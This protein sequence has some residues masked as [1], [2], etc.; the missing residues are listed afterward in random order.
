MASVPSQSE[1]SGKLAKFFNQILQGQRTVKTSRESKQFFEAI[2]DQNDPSKCCERLFASVQALESL[3]AALRSDTS[4]TFI[5][6]SISGFIHYISDPAVKQLCSGQ[7][8]Q[9]LLQVLL[10]PPTLWI[11]LVQ[12]YTNRTMT[13]RTMQGFSWILLEILLSPGHFDID[14][15]D[16][17]KRVV[18]VELVQ[19]S[20]TELRTVLYK[21]QHV[22]SLQSVATTVKLE[23]GPGGRHDNDFEDFRRIAIYPTADEF[24][25]TETPFYRSADMVQET[26]ED[27]RA[28]V[29]IDNQFRLLREDML[30]ELRDDHQRA[31]KS[32]GARRSAFFIP[33]LAGAHLIY[34]DPKQQ[35]QAAI[36]FYCTTGLEQFKGLDQ[37][38]R[39]SFLTENRNFLKHQSF[40]CLIQGSDIISFATVER[41]I[42]SLLKDPPMIVLQ[43]CGDKAFEKTLSALKSGGSLSFLSVDTPFFAYEPVL[44]CLQTKPT[45]ALADELINYNAEAPVH[46]SRLI[47][48]IFVQKVGESVGRDLKPLLQT[49]KSIKLDES[50]TESLK[51]GL[52]LP[53][54]LIQGPP[55][56]GK[57]FIGALLAKSFYDL[58]K[59]IILVVC[60][61]NHAL[62]QFLE[63]FLDIGV[64][65]H[66]I[67][68]LGS[69]STPKTA[70][71]NLF[72]QKSTYKHGRADWAAIDQLRAEANELRV[73]L[74]NKF[75]DYLR[76]RFDHKTLM[77][78]LEFSEH[79]DVFMDALTTPVSADGMVKVGRKGK[80]V[81]PDYLFNQWSNGHGPGVF[82][83]SISPTHRDVWTMTPEA[84]AA[85]ISSW[86]ASLVQERIDVI[87]SLY[88]RYNTVQAKASEI[89]NQRNVE[90]LKTKRII[91]CTTT[92]AAKYAE[93]I[94]HASPGI[95]LVEE[96]G[97][98]LESHILTALS[99]K[100]KQLVLIGDH[101]Q[102]RPKINNYAL[103]VEKGDGFDL[104][105]SLFE[106]LILAGYPHTTLMKQH[107]MSPE[108][109]SLIR[110]L[111]YP[112]LKDAP[113]TMNRPPVRGLQ[114]RVVFFNH[115][116]P[117][118]NMANLNDRRDEGAKVSKR[119]HF[120]GNMVLKCVRYLAQQ[121]YGT[122]KLV[123]LTPY[124]GQLHLLRDLLS[125]ENDPVLNDLDSHDLIKAGLL[126]QSS[127]Y[128]TKRPIKIS[129]IDNYQGEES[130]IVLVSLTRCNES[131]DIG[132]MKA[133]ER[134]NVLLSRARN[135]MILLGSADTF[136]KAHKGRTP[137]VS[138][139]QFMR[140]H[141]H[142]Y[143]GL[144]VLCMQHPDRKSIIQSTEDFDQ[145]CPDGGCFEPCGTKL[146]CGLHDCPSKCHQLADHSKMNCEFIVE[147][148]CPK[149]H[150]IRVR[151]HIKD[152]TCRKCEHEERQK[153]RKKQRDLKLDMERDAKQAA[154]MQ[155]LAE[156]QDEIDFERRKLQNKSE[157]EQRQQALHQRQRDLADIKAI[158]KDIGEIKLSDGCQFPQ[159]PDLRDPVENSGNSSQPD[160]QTAD[161]SSVVQPSSSTASKEWLYQKE[162]EGASNEALDDLM[163][164][165]GLEDVK[166]KF[167]SIKS[168]VDTALR[169]NINLK[170]ERFGAAL[171]GN[172]GTGKTTVARLYARFLTSVGALPGNFFVE[173]SGSK[174]ANEGVSGCKK[175]LEDILNNG[176]GALF[177]DEAYQLA[178]GTN[179]GG[180]SVLDF[181][182][183]EVENTTGKVVFILAG[184]NK[185]MEAFFAHNPGIPSR[186]PHELQFKDYEDDELLRILAHSI[187]KKYS[188]RMKIEDGMG[189]LYSRIV[190][191]RI[192]RGHG[193]EGF[194]NAR[195][196]E[197]ARAQIA[198][199]QA[200]RLQEQRRAKMQVDDMLLTKEDLLGPE[201]A[202]A[203]KNCRAWNQLQQ[204]IG[205]K[206]VK[207]SVQALFDSIQ[208]NYCRELEE[209]PLVEYSLNRVFL[210][211]PGTGKTSVAKLY[212]QILADIGLLSKGEVV[213]KNP[214]DFVGSVLGESEKNTKGI[215]AST[216]GKVLVIDEAYGLFS[217]QG[218]GR[219][220][221]DPYKTAVIDTI[222]A[223]VQ[224]TPGDDRC[225][226]LLGYKDQM[227]EMFQ[228]VNPGLTRRF[229]LDAAFVFEDFSDEELRK[230]F[231]LKI[232]G[233]GFDATDQGKKVAMEMLKRAHN[234]PHFGNAGEVDI[235]LNAAKSRHQ[236]RLSTGKTKK[237]ATLEA[238]DFDEDFDRGQRAETN[239]K[240]LFEGVVGCEDI[241][242]QLERYQ[243]TGKNLKLLDID[244]REQIPFNFLFRGPP[245]TGKTT[246][247]KKMGKIYYD[248]G[249]LATAEV[250]ECSATE[251][252]GQYVGSTG[253]KTQK[254][255]EKALG[256][257][258]F[259]DEAY[260]LA[261]GQFAKEAMDEIVDCLTKPKFAQ[262]LVMILA[263]YD[264]Q[265]NHLMTINPGLTSRFPEAVVFRPLQPDECITLLVGLLRKRKTHLE[266]SG[267]CLDMSVL[268]KPTGSFRNDLHAHFQA[269]TALQDW[270]NAR[271][272]Q[273]IYKS[274]FN[275]LVNSATRVKGVPTLALTSSTVL[276]E[277]S[278]ILS[279]RS[280]RGN[281]ASSFP[282]PNNFS[283]Q[284]QTATRTLD[285]QPLP[286]SSHATSFTLQNQRNDPPPPQETPQQN[287][288][289]EP[290][291]PRDHSVSDAKWAQLQQDKAAASAREHDFADLLAKERDVLSF[292][293]KID[294][295]EAAAEAAAQTALKRAFDERA[296]D[297][298]KRRH[299]QERLKWLK[300]REV[301]E[302][303][304]EELKR[305]K[306]EEMR[307]RE[308]EERAQRRLRDLGI[309]PAGFRWV[310]QA[311]GYRCSAGGH[312]VDDAALG[313]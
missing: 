294:A 83:N 82:V 161:T 142:M 184:Y 70:N 32:K 58:T 302:A 54:S 24:R 225:V 157:E 210:G 252:V 199:R 75:N 218:E 194:G 140:E 226:L 69:K 80:T 139:I 49:A 127:A 212:G 272:V 196:V 148:T 108:I 236:Q 220:Q 76:L 144:P 44:K 204:L 55:G 113:T 12:S 268:E 117:E 51:A 95:V 2:C 217:A 66:A 22:L 39:K 197:N 91:G 206:A 29:H 274:I 121:G 186:F 180:A 101:K 86:K 298:A 169:Q 131:G 124:L 193:K 288:Q 211:S 74:D 284:A 64:P 31:L 244:P 154:Y 10:D 53:V 291:D 166:E 135:G 192:G 33:N 241:I 216:I 122:D 224:S 177:I 87:A 93:D 256:K 11:A 238:H 292:K 132:F 100:T 246:T 17:A 110:H 52:S 128:L 40:G 213:V 300:I 77:D 280:H 207:Q 253:P 65:E 162:F 270:A 35:R 62:D 129:T 281:N 115:N 181:L 214:S 145:K 203:L 96:A 138:F 92:A 8:L 248:M 219:S 303:E 98:I 307:R 152:R 293:A 243:Q 171:L 168:K 97:E 84:R 37:S 262:K 23:N 73:Q 230:I 109:S 310:K 19:P 247:A 107:R 14:I 61:T 71:L 189:G 134:L 57:S 308:R 170:D 259:V 311:G 235:L 67:V 195:A 234:R 156:V 174:L 79:D 85:K 63:D 176:G 191:R 18:T 88:R 267:K 221:Q 15:L 299:E 146:N 163:K 150:R 279:E 264:A 72:G 289:P 1:R 125:K 263:G 306:E 278:S 130:D 16:I 287:Q 239:I 59:E 227:E 34:G 232:K 237:Q 56:T 26:S 229:P 205:L 25:S 266:K 47:D 38:R 228:K 164:M 4:S 167:L 245:G 231:D 13:D 297:E 112:D 187:D 21:L 271:D 223:E 133:P 104:N 198:G 50:Q 137:W 257:V 222:V 202:A 269:L 312:F 43:V 5:N 90:I 41:D 7:V 313:L 141:K 99:S 48:N 165:I 285:P 185:N 233:Q 175:H 106:R 250:I 114:D 242:A 111:T 149:K 9:R 173:T 215:L 283:P 153:E 301:Y 147:T 190:A 136:M 78:L 160:Q 42:D 188:S 123:V 27:E 151:C 261:E 295:E 60:Y 45:L 309:C 30:A 119:N 28:A 182:L 172:P 46:H 304:V 240:L 103:T 251:L 277:V 143:D 255:L 126:S 118:D 305:R 249:F 282:P 3:R 178:S 258:L 286:P 158:T 201:P 120:E 179:Y 102:L 296:I 276:T 105:R 265:I 290:Q 36:S 159:M 20:T 155:K 68:R 94:Q 6:E 208:Y 254:L 275:K 89:W 183:T 116:H 209:K 200:K 81:G 273:T 260:R